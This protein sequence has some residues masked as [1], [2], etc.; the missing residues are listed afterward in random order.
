M[1]KP[2]PLFISPENMA[3]ATDLYELTMAAGYFEAGLEESLT[4][5][6]S[7]RDLPASRSFLLAAGLEQ[8][9]HFVTNLRFTDDAVSYL[10]SLKPF[11]HISAEFFDHLRALR[12]SGDIFA[13]E[14]GT[15][16]FP[17]EPVLV[18]SG[19]PVEAQILE[20]FL[21]TTINFQTV[22]ASKA[23]RVV[24]AADGRSVI[25]FG[26]RRAFLDHGF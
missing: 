7:V 13:L 23:A 21:L 24:H 17:G 11:E 25:D 5:E 18:V 12:F 8:I 3:L 22:V 1:K 14:E 26:S 4:F 19:P 20:T 6:L 2:N 10:R 9:V 15:V 16:F